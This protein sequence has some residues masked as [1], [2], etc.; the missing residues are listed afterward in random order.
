[1]MKPDRPNA[2]ARGSTHQRSRLAV[3]PKPCFVETAVCATV[4]LLRSV[5]LE[6]SDNSACVQ[7]HF[8]NAALRRPR[9]GPPGVGER[10]AFG[11]HIQHLD[12]M[13]A[14]Q[15]QRGFEPAAARTYKRDFMTFHMNGAH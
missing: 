4:R 1:M 13:G 3:L 11:N 7:Q 9:K 5:F 6:Y 14:K 12:A 2:M 8:E 15:L 10:K